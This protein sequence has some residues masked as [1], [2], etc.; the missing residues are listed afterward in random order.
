MA[1]RR[2]LKDFDLQRIQSGF[3]TSLE[4]LGFLVP[5]LGSNSTEEWQFHR[6]HNPQ[7]SPA[8]RN[9]HKYA[10]SSQKK[11]YV[12]LEAFLEFGGE[13]R[14]TEMRLWQMIVDG[15]TVSGDAVDSL[16]YVG[17]ADIVNP[18]VT[19]LM[20]E[21]WSDQLSQ[22]RQELGTE[23]Q[24]VLTITP[25]NGQTWS[26]NPFI[27]C[28]VR[29]AASLSTADKTV[30]C[31]KAYLIKQNDIGRYMLLEFSN[32]GSSQ[33]NN[34]REALMHKV[35]P[36]TDHN[37]AQKQTARAAGDEWEEVILLSPQK[38]PRAKQ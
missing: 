24:R 27:R 21:E 23:V 7:L 6:V 17:F 38:T 36:M 10:C 4:P 14:V 25:E 2:S 20:D 30:K 32:V 37:L 35:E 9:L 15:W 19:N 16:R 5:F 22:H 12:V 34:E 1:V 31:V 28:G 13:V 26:R 8:L 3:S 18:T 29:V 11:A 33:A